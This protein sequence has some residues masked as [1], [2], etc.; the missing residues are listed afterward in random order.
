MIGLSHPT[1]KL[2]G[3]IELPA[4]K[5]ISNRLVI[6][7]QHHHEL[8]IKNLSYADDTQLLVKGV[9]NPEQEIYVGHGGTT[10]RFL[11]AH[12]ALQKG[13]DKVIIGSKRLHERPVKPLVEVLRQLGCQITYLGKKGFFPLRVKGV[14]PQ[15]NEVEV[16]VEQSSQFLT[17]IA[18]QARSFKEGLEINYEADKMVSMPYA[19]LTFSLLKA[20]GYS[21]SQSKNGAFIKFQDLAQSEFTVEP[22]WS[23][24]SYFMGMA[25]LANEADINF[26]SLP[27][28]SLQGDAKQVQIFRHMGLSIADEKDG[29]SVCK[30]HRLSLGNL[31]LNCREIPDLAQTF[32]VVFSG[33]GISFHL[34]GLTTLPLKETDRLHAL[35]KELEKIGVRVKKGSDWISG[36]GKSKIERQVFSTY[37]D[38]R[39]AMSF[40]MLGLLGKVNIAEEHAVS[41]SFPGFWETL[42]NLGFVMEI[43]S[44]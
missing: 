8:V 38:H 39:M 37:H 10:A 44:K 21:V 25:A 13:A 19:N 7:Q 9:K 2:E 5:S 14:A 3:S 31:Q 22:D 42:K 1:K 34:S 17:A 15:K 33:L 16:P 20:I 24:A 30:R 28:T 29:L 35:Q 18:L 32:A 26:P 41:K 12:F 6:L 4:S 27:L 36:E 23:A 40:A 11:L 43:T